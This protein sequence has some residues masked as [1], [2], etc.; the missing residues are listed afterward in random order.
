[1]P[2]CPSGT[3]FY[4]YSPFKGSILADVLA[5]LRIESTRRHIKVC[6]LGPCSRRVSNET[7]LKT[8]ASSDT[9]NV[10]VFVSR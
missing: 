5:A 4:L 7:W 1:M 9:G 10:A 8:T 6:T 3:V 2:I